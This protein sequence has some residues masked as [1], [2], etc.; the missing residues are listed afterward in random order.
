MDN[1][2]DIKAIDLS[3]REYKVKEIYSSGYIIA[4]ISNNEKY[5]AYG[6]GRKRYWKSMT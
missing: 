4:D 6:G 3:K 2:K 1:D 5:L